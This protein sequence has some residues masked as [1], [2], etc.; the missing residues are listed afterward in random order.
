MLITIGGVFAPSL[1]YILTLGSFEIHHDAL[2]SP[3]WV[4]HN[5]GQVCCKGCTKLRRRSLIYRYVFR[6]SACGWRGRHIK[7]L[8]CRSI[9]QMSSR[10]IWLQTGFNG[11]FHAMKTKSRKTV[12]YVDMASDVSKDHRVRLG[13]RIVRTTLVPIS[14]GNIFCGYKQHYKGNCGKLMYGC[15]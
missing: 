2:C 9:E 4:G 10:D 15:T 14:R 6:F 7:E 12:K 5:F 8:L 1:E 3:S 13:H 11:W